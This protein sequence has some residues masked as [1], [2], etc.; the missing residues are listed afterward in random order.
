MDVYQYKYLKYKQKYR[1][2]VEQIAYG[3]KPI[4]NKNITLD[5]DK[6]NENSILG[7]VVVKTGD[8]FDLPKTITTYLTNDG[9]KI[10]IDL[11]IA[12]GSINKQFPD[13]AW[14]STNPKFVDL[15]DDQNKI[16][17]RNNDPT[18]NKGNTDILSGKVLW[19]QRIPDTVTKLQDKLDNTKVDEFN[20]FK[21]SLNMEP[22]TRIMIF[23]SISKLKNTGR[24]RKPKIE[25]TEITPTLEGGHLEIVVGILNNMKDL[26]YLD[27]CSKIS[28]ITISANGSYT[29]P[30]HILIVYGKEDDTRSTTYMIALV[31]YEQLIKSENQELAGIET[32]C[33]PH[34]MP[35]K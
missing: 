1:N 3:G 8:T 35:W 4:L 11:V 32:L 14:G 13:I 29:D 28:S 26:Y 9:N 15:D 17:A 23:N 20:K 34:S 25:A 27:S 12:L 5:S 31:K 18:Y 21:A 6:V 16:T 22:T 30:K 33:N 10:D 7:S 19:T 2:L 24:G